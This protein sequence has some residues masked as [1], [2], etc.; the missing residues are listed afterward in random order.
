MTWKLLFVISDQ[1]LGRCKSWLF[2]VEQF[3]I[4]DLLVNFSGKFSGN[5]RFRILC[6]STNISYYINLSKGILSQTQFSLCIPLLIHFMALDC[7]FCSVSSLVPEMQPHI[8]LPYLRWLSLS[9]RCTAA[10]FDWGRIS[11]SL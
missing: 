3:E 10:S 8:M 7:V 2:L 4:L 5:L 9:A 6:V 1:G 11:F